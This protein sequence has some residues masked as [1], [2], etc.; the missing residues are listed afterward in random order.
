[1]SA[2][3][4]VFDNGY[5]GCLQPILVHDCL[6]G[7]AAYS[8]IR[9]ILQFYKYVKLISM[10]FFEILKR[11]EGPYQYPVSQMLNTPPHIASQRRRLGERRF[12]EFA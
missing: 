5:M 12:E 10:E 2:A 6:A 1:M 3:L 11:L 4:C 8:P 9:E 7:M